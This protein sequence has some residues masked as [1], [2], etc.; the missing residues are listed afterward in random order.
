MKIKVFLMTLVFS[1]GVIGGYAQKGVDNGTQYGSGEDSVRCIRNLSLY[2]PY[3][4]A[5]NY[6]DAYEFWKQAYDE[7][8]AA[9]KDIYLYG[10]RIV[11]WEIANEKDPAKKEELIDKLMA[12]YDQRVKYFGN[13]KRYGKD[14]IVSRKAQD[15]IQQKGESFDA[16]LVYGWL[17]EIIDEYGNDTES[18][19]ISLYML[20]AHRMVMEDPNTKEQY[21]E[22]FLRIS[23]ILETQLAAAKVANNTKDIETLTGFKTAIEGG[24]AGSGAADCETLQGLY[25]DKVEQNKADMGFLKETLTLLRRVG[26]NDIEVYYAASRYLHQNNPTP[27]SA[28]GLGKQAIRDKDYET[29]VKYIEEAAS[30]DT[31]ANSKADDFYMIALLMYEQNN[32]SR[33]RQYAN[34]A[35]EQNPAYGKAYILIGNMYAATAKSVYPNDAVLYKASFNAVI[36]KFERAKQVDPSV[37]EEANKLIGTYRAHL[38]STEDVFMHP[39]LE[40]GKS[41]TVGGWINERTTI[42]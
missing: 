36:D 12:V 42:R 2:L 34:K 15:Y 33:A 18:L 38:P 8:P 23:S 37:A 30:L 22:D 32:Y 1:M 5:G 13:D 24:F 10:V 25:A 17:K 20:A 39:D 7:C 40:K 16:K 9:N 6:K 11:G 29:A 41:F 3:A 4:K 31:D 14:W 27:E 21:V 28:I 35:L 26:C 19:A